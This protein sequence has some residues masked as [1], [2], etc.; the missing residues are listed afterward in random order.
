M[1]L[2][3]GTLPDHREKTSAHASLSGS[4]RYGGMAEERA[5]SAARFIRPDARRISRVGVAEPQGTA[6]GERRCARTQ[7]QHPKSEGDEHAPRATR[8]GAASRRDAAA[9]GVRGLHQAKWKK[10][11]KRKGQRSRRDDPDGFGEEIRS[12][13]DAEQ[14]QD[15]EGADASARCAR[16]SCRSAAC[17]GSCGRARQCWSFL[18]EIRMVDEDQE[19]AEVEERKRRLSWSGSQR[20][21]ESGVEPATAGAGRPRIM[22]S[23]LRVR[24]G[25]GVGRLAPRSGSGLSCLPGFGNLN[26]FCPR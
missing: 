4:D 26:L 5:A 15:D 25:R 2:R 6:Y 21:W 11:Q 18:Q 19:A 12:R 22:N 8:L 1:V 3:H 20:G 16:S 9:C 17:A 14:F 7:G 24:G 23:E 10:D 13:V